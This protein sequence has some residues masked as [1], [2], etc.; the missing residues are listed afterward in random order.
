MGVGIAFSGRV[1]GVSEPPYVGLNLAEHVGDRAERVN[2]NRDTLF[3]VLGLASVRDRAVCAEQVHGAAIALVAEADAGSGAFAAQDP[4]PIPRTDALMTST[5]GIP[6]MMFFADCVP[7]ILVAPGSAVAVVHAGWR[8]ALARLPGLTVLKMSEEW[9][10]RPRDICA[11]VGPHISAQEYE[12]DAR[13]MSQFVNSFGTVARAES[14]GLDLGAVVNV[15][16]VD[17]G[18]DSCNILALGLCTAQSTDRLFS[19]RAEGGLTGRHAAIA[20]VLPR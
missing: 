14:G 20:Y 10:C 11:Y 13:I 12:V 7:V 8:G 3:D 1:G 5:P 15:S 16:L 19:Y 9:G 18:V 17:S 4:G 2:H 6:L